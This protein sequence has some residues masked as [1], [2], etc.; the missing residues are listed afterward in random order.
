MFKNS[1]IRRKLIA[2]IILGGMIP[3]LIGSIY[4]VDSSR[5][6]MYKNNLDN[7]KIMLEQMAVYVDGVI[8]K[9]MEGIVGAVSQEERLMTASGSIKKYTEF[10]PQILSQEP[11]QKEKEIY[12]L[13]KNITENN[14]NITFI[15]FGTSDGGYV[16]YPQFN[17]KESYDPRSRDWYKNAL[18]KEGVSISEPYLTKVSGEI[19]VSVDKRVINEG[20]TVGVISLTINIEKFISSL[21]MTKYGKT[22]YVSI[23]SS[24]G[25]FINSPA[26]PDWLMKQSSE[27]LPQVYGEYRSVDGDFYESE[28][29]GESGTSTKVISTYESPYSGWKYISV[30]D[31]SEVMDEVTRWVSFLIITITSIILITVFIII[32][33]SGYITKPILKISKMINKMSS[34][35]FEDYEN[36]SL[37]E[38]NIRKDEI[39]EISRA[40]SGM[41][42]NFTELKNNIY[43]MDLQIKNIDI[44]E[45][46]L[47]KLTMSKENPFS[48]VADSVNDLLGRVNKYVE[49]IKTQ[50]EHIH[51]LAHNDIMTKLPNRIRF[52]EKLQEVINSGAKGGVILIDIDDFK[53]INDSMGHMYGDKVISTVAQRLTEISDKLTFVSRFGGDEFLIL[54]EYKDDIHDLVSY[55]LNIFVAM[56]KEFEIEQNKIKIEISVGVSV[57]PKDSSDVD[58][59]MMYA[60][61]AMYTVKNSGKNNYA[62]FNIPMA[63][64]LKRNMEIKKILSEAIESEA[65]KILYQPQVELKTGEIVGFEALVRLKNHNISPGEFIPVAEENGTIIPIGRLVTRMAI[66]QMKTWSDRG[67]EPKPVAINFSAVQIHDI[68]YKSYLMSLL[69]ENEIDPQ[70]IT[71]EITEGIFLEHKDTTIYLLKELRSHG[72]KIAIDDF[73]TGFSS[74]SYLTTLPIDCIKFDRMLSMKFLEVEDISVIKSL[75]SL[76]HGLDLKVVAEG[77]EDLKQVEKLKDGNCDTIQGYYFSKPLEAKDAEAIYNHKYEV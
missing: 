74:L 72:I 22:G 71:I 53:G 9:N 29:K 10:S 25:V 7:N 55:I 19:V 58:E 48:R 23:L 41:Q 76:S 64:N 32:F 47:N 12:D 51:F 2:G 30:I 20:K 11:S 15:S 1:S 13:F 5:N 40:M 38:Y 24:E 49:K 46:G 18:E 69:K 35:D 28:F 66:E 60:D 8:L 6:W 68:G 4:I 26:N 54:Y 37:E 3:S 67:L 62:F 43:D 63:Q 73:G 59:L 65:F 14:E 57:F 45:S 34:F 42:K 70:M 39:G 17:P 27:V 44:S 56:E 50:N 21:K 36:R 16:E 31:K 61:I 33:L 77:I 52:N 75:I